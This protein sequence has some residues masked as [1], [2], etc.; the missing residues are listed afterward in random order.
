MI[1]TKKK[2]RIQLK[3][4]IR[5]ASVPPLEYSNSKELT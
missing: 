5:K 4:P 1:F 3:L 2:N